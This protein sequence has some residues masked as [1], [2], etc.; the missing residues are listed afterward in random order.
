MQTYFFNIETEITGIQVHSF[1]TEAET[2]EQAQTRMLETFEKLN[3]TVTGVTPCF[4]G[5]ADVEFC[6][7]YVHDES[8]AFELTT[9]RPYISLHCSQQ[10]EHHIATRAA[11]KLSY[12]AQVE[13]VRQ[14]MIAKIA[15]LVTEFGTEEENTFNRV[16]GI[17]L[18]ED[19]SDDWL[20]LIADQ[21]PAHC[22]TADYLIEE[23]GLQ[24]SFNSISIE[25]LA[26][27]T[28]KLIELTQ[29]RV[30]I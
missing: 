25:M 30:T 2:Y 19:E 3:E 12:E 20:L 1:R 21:Y 8:L 14:Q 4:E 6:E 5:V 7:S 22:V 26:A 17:S 16:K 23:E 24:Y 15:E 9:D 18:V 13:A 29:I 28:D 27:L 10:S 11:P